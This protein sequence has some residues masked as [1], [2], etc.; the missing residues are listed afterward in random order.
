MKK[1]LVIEDD[2]NVRESIAE[3]LSLKPYE[4]ATAE[5][6]LEGVRM[7]KETNPD[8]IIC[9][10]MMPE[11]DGY[12]VLGKLRSDEYNSDVPFIFLTAKAE[13]TS[14]R[15]GMNLGADDYITKPF[16]AEE[17]FEAIEARIIKQEKAGKAM[18][19]RIKLS[20][21]LNEAIANNKIAS[22]FVNIQG[23]SNMI[24]DYF[25]DYTEDAI[26]EIIEDIRSSATKAERVIKNA[27]LYQSLVEAEN[28]ET[29]AREFKD[30]HCNCIEEIIRTKMF[31]IAKNYDRERDI[32]FKEVEKRN[33]GISFE[34]LSAIIHE[35]IDNAFK[36]SKKGSVVT[37]SGAVVQSK[38]ILTIEDKGMG[39][40][41][42]QLGELFSDRQNTRYAL[43]G[44]VLVHKLMRFLN[45]DI[46]IESYL[47]QGTKVMLSFSLH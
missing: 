12:E 25:E 41:K 19:S 35:V 43:S 44:L 37:V 20:Q 26:K 33:L 39:V 10:V 1:I 3:L 21:P 24:L 17:L 9:D 29:R 34:G 18:T 28:D 23:L 16:K 46:K 38:Y 36:F 40:S 13:K 5:N 8:L 42:S 7:A 31:G 15:Q 2:Q 45:N 32:F 11:S 22:S 27:V 47:E 4:V 6:G 30:V 14:L